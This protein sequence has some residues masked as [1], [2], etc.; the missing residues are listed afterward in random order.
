[1]ILGMRWVDCDYDCSHAV[2]P[3]TYHRYFSDEVIKTKQK[4]TGQT[5]IKTIDSCK[6][7][8]K[9]CIIYTNNTGILYYM[10]LIYFPT[11]LGTMSMQV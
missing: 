7:V 10:K 6:L 4:K 5:N 9:S 11:M 3:S 2:C 1:M 8:A